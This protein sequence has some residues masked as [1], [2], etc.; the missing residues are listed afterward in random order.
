MCQLRNLRSIYAG[1]NRL[2][3]SRAMFSTVEGLVCTAGCVQSR[4][5]AKQ[6]VYS[7]LLVS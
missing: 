3:S 2:C 7:D 4:D 5:R 1:E 6:I